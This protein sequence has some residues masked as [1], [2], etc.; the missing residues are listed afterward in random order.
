MNRPRLWEWGEGAERIRR[1]TLRASA[2]RDRW[3]EETLGTVIEVVHCQ[4]DWADSLVE[5]SENALDSSLN[6]WRGGEDYFTT[7]SEF[8]G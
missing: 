1:C 6:L 4:A 8:E 7:P 3:P 5:S 2:E